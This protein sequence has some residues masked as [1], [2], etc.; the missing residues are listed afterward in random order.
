L[1]KISRQGDLTQYI[2]PEFYKK[3]PSRYNEKD[4]KYCR[5]IPKKDYENTERYDERRPYREE[6]RSNH[7]SPPTRH[8]TPTVNVIAGGIASGGDTMR[9]SRS[10]SRATS[11]HAILEMHKK[12]PRPEEAITFSEKDGTG[13][14]QPHDDALVLSL[15]INTHR[16]RRILIDIGSS[17]DVMYFDAFTKM[18]YGP[19]HLV[20][21]HT[22][23]VGFTGVAMVPKCL[24][25]MKAPSA[26]NVILGRNTLYELG[27]TIFIPCLKMKFLT[28]HGVGEECGDQQMSRDYYVISLKGQGGQ[29]NQVNTKVLGRCIPHLS[30]N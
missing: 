10:Y 5:K 27:A 21:V 13:V 23:L 6:G 3:Y 7:N 11:A 19:L 26:Y 15:K 25:R 16:V 2:K 9:Q 12:R 24:M 20:K 17:A 30:G 4:R 8:P 18:V 28:T 29:V 1:E 22:P 14:S